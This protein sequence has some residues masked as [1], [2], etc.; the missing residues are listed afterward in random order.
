MWKSETI[1]S[2]GDMRQDEKL[3]DDFI[4]EEY[5]GNYFERLE[6]VE[7]MIVRLQYEK[8]LL[9]EKTKAT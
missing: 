9:E 2:I 3:Y 1:F 4:S 8:K 5:E 6:H 7:R